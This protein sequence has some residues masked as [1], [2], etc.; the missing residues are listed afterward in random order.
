M[1]TVTRIVDWLDG[2]HTPN[3][4]RLGRV[5]IPLLFAGLVVL[6]PWWSAP[7]MGAPLA[8]SPQSPAGTWNANCENSR[9][10]TILITLSSATRATATITTVG[11]ASQFGYHTGDQIMRLE[12]GSGGQWTGTLYWRNTAGVKHWQPITLV[13]KGAK[14]H[15][16]S[17]SENC[18]EEM[19]RAK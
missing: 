16:V 17:D 2:P 18:Y 4:A 5:G 15:G 3:A 19:D 10:M 14:L 13:R 8:T 6:L 1:R 7:A 12:A 9:G 11:A